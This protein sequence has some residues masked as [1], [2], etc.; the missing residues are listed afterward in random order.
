MRHNSATAT[1]SA[2]LLD[3]DVKAQET[4]PLNSMHVVENPNYFNKP[5]DK[6][7]AGLYI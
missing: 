4:M 5:G 7:T 6:S 3:K 2:A 1:T